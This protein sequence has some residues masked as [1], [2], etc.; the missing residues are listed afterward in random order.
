MICARGQMLV[1]S[2]LCGWSL[3]GTWGCR[4]SSP[5][6]PTSPSPSPMTCTVRSEP[7]EL[8]TCATVCVARYVH[9]YMLLVKSIRIEECLET[10]SGEE[11]SSGRYNPVGCLQQSIRMYIHTCVRISGLCDSGKAYHNNKHHYCDSNDSNAIP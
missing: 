3:T 2:V 4:S 8:D 9:T 5:S 7:C 1:R 6:T 11:N 10:Q